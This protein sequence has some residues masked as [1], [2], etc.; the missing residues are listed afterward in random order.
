MATRLMRLQLSI[1][2]SRTLPCI[3]PT[4]RQDNTKEDPRSLVN[5]NSRETT[6]R[7]ERRGCRAE[8]RREALDL[9]LEIDAQR[10]HPRHL[11]MLGPDSDFSLLTGLVSI[12]ELVRH[13]RIGQF[14]RETDYQKWNSCRARLTYNI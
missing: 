6:L 13:Q 12:T 14:T 3:A 2:S 9:Q 4:P 1:P 10:K 5:E 7:T 11:A 8:G